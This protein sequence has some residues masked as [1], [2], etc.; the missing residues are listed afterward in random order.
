[1][2][3]PA[4]CERCG[5]LF[6]LQDFFMGA[7]VRKVTITN[8]RTRCPKCGGTAKILDGTYEFYNGM[9]ETVRGSH[10]TIEAAKKLKEITQEVLNSDLN[11]TQLRD[12]LSL[13]DKATGLN[14][15]NLHDADMTNKSIIIAL[16]VLAIYFTAMI[17]ELGVKTTDA[18][19]DNFSQ[20]TPQIEK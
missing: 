20:N 10:L 14:L 12:R 8:S 13:I 4:I 3:I 15:T 11:S 16:T 17:A 18:L 19:I 9:L 1:M 5:H 7:N 6:A 2:S